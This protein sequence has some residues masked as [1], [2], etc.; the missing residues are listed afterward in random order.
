MIRCTFEV[1]VAA[2]LIH[3]ARKVENMIV[4]RNVSWNFENQLI[5]SSEESQSDEAVDHLE[6][7]LARAGAGQHLAGPRQLQLCQ[8]ADQ[9]RHLDLGRLCLPCGLCL[10][11]GDRAGG[12]GDQ[13]R[14]NSS[15]SSGTRNNSSNT[16]VN[17]FD[18]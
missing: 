7:D 10:Q 11:V 18:C 9:H 15:K 3:G 12:G 13:S 2:L 16:F 14:N 1:V 6:W 5:T 8:R 4:A 17:H